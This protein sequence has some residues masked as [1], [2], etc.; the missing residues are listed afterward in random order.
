MMLL[1]ERWLCGCTRKILL[2][3]G[4]LNQELKKIDHI[5]I[6]GKPEVS[7]L[8]LG[9][10]AFDIFRLGNMLTS[11]G[12]SLTMLQFPSSIHISLTLLHTKPGVAQQF[13]N[14]IQESVS[15]IM[16]DP[17][18]KTTG[19]GAIYGMAQTIPD[20]S[21]ITDISHVFLDALYNTEPL[22]ADSTLVNGSH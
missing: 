14:D 16:K 20:R 15:E 4:L 3:H 21:M 11:K 17:K 5:F 6:F 2:P 18:A 10:D 13:V 1:G 7:V 22:S 12:W 9:S 19:V 8:A